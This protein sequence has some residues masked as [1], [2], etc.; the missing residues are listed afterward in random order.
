M[1]ANFKH[2]CFEYTQFTQCNMTRSDFRGTYGYII[3]IQSNKLKKAKFS[4][5]EVRNLLIS[6]DIVID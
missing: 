5:L 2:I 6:I 4:F 1:D 3:D